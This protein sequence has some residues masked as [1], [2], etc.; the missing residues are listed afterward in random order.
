MLPLI[1]TIYIHIRLSIVENT[2]C[3]LD[4][5]SFKDEPVS[6]FDFSSKHMQSAQ[7]SLSLAYG[8]IVC[9][10]DLKQGPDLSYDA[11]KRQGPTMT[12]LLK[13][14]ADTDF[15][16]MMSFHYR[17]IATS[18]SGMLDKIVYKLEYIPFRIFFYSYH[19][20]HLQF[21]SKSQENHQS[22]TF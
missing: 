20:Q 21:Y 16:P 14:F 19:H 18:M 10:I 13:R 9:E 5:Q 3:C 11:T 1:N 7:T 2:E 8:D 22:S 12:S 17:Y 6:L 15:V 4:P